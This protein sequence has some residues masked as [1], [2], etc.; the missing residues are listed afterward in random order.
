MT[1]PGDTNPAPSSSSSS[2]SESPIT[3]LLNSLGMTRDD[4]ERHTFRMRLF[5]DSEET[6]KIVRAQAAGDLGDSARALSQEEMLAYIKKSASAHESSKTTKM[7]PPTRTSHHRSSTPSPDEAPSLRHSR[8]TSCISKRRSN[9]DVDSESSAER[10]ATRRAR[11]STLVRHRTRTATSPSRPKLSL[12]EVM[13]MR[14]KQSRRVSSSE[15]SEESGDE[16]LRVSFMPFHRVVTVL[17]IYLDI[18]RI[19]SHHFFRGELGCFC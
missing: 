1:S 10:G 6:R 8:S 16:S 15:E 9:D 4:L 2:S 3:Q 12:D 14:S 5:L 13:Q 11:A 18:R 7:P 17:K 19:N